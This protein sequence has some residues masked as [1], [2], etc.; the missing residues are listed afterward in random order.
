MG[1][2]TKVERTIV[3]NLN[4]QRQWHLNNVGRF[5]YRYYSLNFGFYMDLV[6]SI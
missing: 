5:M 4:F 1:M 6:L 2:R 3:F